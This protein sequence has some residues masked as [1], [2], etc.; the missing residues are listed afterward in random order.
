MRIIAVYC[1]VSS[2]DQRDRETIRTQQDTIERALAGL[3][4]VTVFRWYLDDGVSGTV[5]MEQRPH[6]RLLM[7]DARAGRFTEIW[8]TRASRVS[9]D[10]VEALGLYAF[11]E[12]IGIA[13]VGVSEPVGDRTMFGF[14][15]I[16]H[17]AGR[18]QFLAD[19]A[20]G[21]ERAAREG[22][23]CG[24]IVPIGYRAEGKKPHT[25]LVPSDILIWRD[26]SE[27][28]LVRRMY[29][30]LLEGSTCPKI[31]DRLNDL[32]VPTVYQKDGREVRR[33]E[34]KR[35]TDC[36]WRPGRIIS[37]VTNPIYRG[38]YHYGRRSKKHGR[39]IITAPVAALVSAEVW[40][41]TQDALARNRIMAKNTDR[42]Y[43]LRSV[44]KCSLCGL[45]YTATWS[46]S[47]TW[48]RCN[49]QITYRGPAVGRCRSRFIRARWLEPLVWADIEKFLRNPGA[50]IDELEAERHDTGAA[51][52]REAERQFAEQALA[53]V[54][55][56]RDRVLD[57]YRRDFIKV[58]DFEKQMRNIDEEECQYREQL[59]AL[60]P[61]ED[62]AND[63]APSI[64][65]LSELRRRL[66]DGLDDTTRQ[67]IV[68]LL[69]QKIV[70]QTEMV[71]AKKHATVTIHYRFPGVVPTDTGTD[72]APRPA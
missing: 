55:G 57:A 70:V 1:R 64:D 62:A 72:S 9:R 15:S 41:A 47:E 28:D 44:M 63:D 31:A 3:D 66:D 8:F 20:K 71:D 52:L 13:L 67:E 22:R 11:F 34:R 35:R 14:A 50:L 56:Q 10:E 2:D 19:S 65:I 33:G 6:G 29:G 17:A 16:M 48:Y 45:T 43:L 38:E 24:G 49:G 27:A 42:V 51:A 23:Y 32:G 68:A 5:P 61:Q 25:R 4:D 18:R 30:W 39:P 53:R 46:K 40:H 54:P 37:I 59:S 60:A 21:I 26:W 12:G 58:E 36:V 69:V 7:A